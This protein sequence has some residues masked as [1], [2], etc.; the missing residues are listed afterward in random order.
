MWD[1]KVTRTLKYKSP[2]KTKYIRILHMFNMFK[3]KD[4]PV[5]TDFAA[6][7]FLNRLI[8]AGAEREFV[9][10]VCAIWFLQ[11]SN[12]PNTPESQQIA[13]GIVGTLENFFVV[14]AAA[15]DADVFKLF[16]RT[17]NNSEYGALFEESQTIYT[18]GR[19]EVNE[20]FPPGSKGVME[21]YAHYANVMLK[22]TKQDKKTLLSTLNALAEY[23]DKMCGLA[24]QAEKNPF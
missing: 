19:N 21:I 15:I 17:I 22:T 8:T 5:T 10:A 6:I 4:K 11:A 23:V 14:E 24:N 3:K 7:S 13:G 18:A 12:D 2:T 16:T 9:N 20:K 1:L